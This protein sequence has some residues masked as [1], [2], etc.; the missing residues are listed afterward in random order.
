MSSQEFSIDDLEMKAKRRVVE[1][2]FKRPK[3]ED[4]DLPKVDME[5]VRVAAEQVL[6][7]GIGIGVLLARGIVK[8]VSAANKAGLET[9]ENPGPLT[10]ALLGLIRKPQ[11]APLSEAATKI[12]VPVLPIENY[13]ELSAPKVVEQLPNLTAEQLTVVRKYELEHKKRTTVLKAI[14]R[15]ANRN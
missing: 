8:A 12:V 10:K 1:F 5:P 6:L 11:E 13:D 4:L 9:A 3:L 2:E 7:T 14:D 15:Y